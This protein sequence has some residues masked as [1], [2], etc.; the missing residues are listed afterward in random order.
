MKTFFQC[1]FKP[2]RFLKILLNLQPKKSL[3]FF[4]HVQYN[5]HK[6]QCFSHYLHIYGKH[7][8]T[9]C[10]V[11]YQTDVFL[12][13][14][15][16]ILIPSRCFCPSMTV[17]VQNGKNQ[18]GQYCHICAEVSRTHDTLNICQFIE[19]KKTRGRFSRVLLLVN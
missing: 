17:S 4:A 2:V 6:S 12:H 10:C 1:V 8:S 19:R 7:H 3:Y 14:T 16:L 15:F 9:A 5:R 13:L 11:D 18:T